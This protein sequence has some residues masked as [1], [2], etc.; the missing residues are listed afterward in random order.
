MV[1]LKIGYPLNSYP[2]TIST[3]SECDINENT[4]LSSIDNFNGVESSVIIA[5]GIVYVIP[6]D[7]SLGN[8][9]I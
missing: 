8:Q 6:T 5:I 4:S 1:L 3:S 9:K 2:S 7:C